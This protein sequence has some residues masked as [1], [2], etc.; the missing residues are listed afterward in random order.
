MEKKKLDSKALEVLFPHG[1]VALTDEVTIQVRPLSLKD[2]PK[3]TDSFG[4]VMK[5]TEAGSSPSE[6][7]AK[8]LQ[9]VIHL[10]QYTV[11]IDPDHIPAS[12]VPDLLEVV[13]EQNMSADILK[14][15]MA[16]VQK[17]NGLGESAKPAKDQSQKKK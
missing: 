4:V 3:V 8:A 6:I 9:E 13:V 12:V 15:W 14:K 16:L 17:M 5:L 7:A 2:L 1:E 11:D 10:I